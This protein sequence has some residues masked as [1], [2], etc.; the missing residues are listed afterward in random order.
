MGRYIR[1]IDVTTVI[2]IILI[3]SVGLFLLLT[4]DT[5]LFFQQLT[6]LV[7][8]FLLMVLLSNI[9]SLVLRWFAPFGY[10]LANILLLFPFMSSAIRG[11][12][13][14]VLIGGV[15][16][17]PSE[18]VKPLLLLSYAY[19]I[20]TYPPKKFPIIL[21]HV[22]LF[23]IPFFLVFSQPDLGSS[24]I[25]LAMWLSMM[26]FGGLPLPFVA[27]VFLICPLAVPLV[28]RMLAQYQKMR[29]MSFLNPTLDPEGVGYN[30]L[31]SM[32]A[33]GS[34]MV[35]GRGLGLGTQSHLRFLPEY[36]TDFAFASLV[37]EL[38]LGGGV[39]L[40]GLY[41]ILL[42]KLIL[43]YIR[44]VEEDAIQSL[45]TIGLFSLIA[46]QVIVNVGM[47]MGIIPVTGITLPFVSYGGSSILG[48]M[49]SFGLL[50]G[51]RTNLKR[52][53]S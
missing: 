19:F 40:L 16:L 30:A 43:P 25:Y 1:S 10:I 26:V 24:I 35:F 23:L 29:I 18:L 34:G 2:T 45:Y 47:N 14:W 20:R 51:L 12:H 50:W 5:P 31:Q 44:K 52:P 7:V 49:A 17:Q 38:G 36:H 11:A 42:W 15:Q 9:D 41:G 22:L 27:M 8:G 33:V 53:F 4:T 32:I 39:F 46:C 28:W 37:E 48:L 6:F 3:G 13:R 21:F